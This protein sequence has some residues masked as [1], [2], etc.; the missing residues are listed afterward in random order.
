MR[1]AAG[2]NRADASGRLRADRP[3]ART[4]ADGPTG[5]VRGDRLGAGGP[6]VVGGP[7]RSLRLFRVDPHLKV[8]KEGG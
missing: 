3:G 7:T 4:A 1:N 5:R 8:Y 6:A 2:P